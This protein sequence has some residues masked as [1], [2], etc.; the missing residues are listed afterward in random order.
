MNTLHLNSDQISTP[1][2]VQ[3]YFQEDPGFAAQAATYLYFQLL[4]L[5]KN[6]KLLE[7]QYDTL[8][9]Q[10]FN[11]R[12]LM[13]LCGLFMWLLLVRLSLLSIC[14]LFFREVTDRETSSS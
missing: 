1:A 10:Y 14:L 4:E 9:Q 6:Q 8:I 3:H 13:M 5:S 2:E 7:K 11:L 12:K